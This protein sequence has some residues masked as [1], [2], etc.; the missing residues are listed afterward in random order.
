MNL[1]EL[2]NK[3]GEYLTYDHQ[4]TVTIIDVNSGLLYSIDTV[5]LQYDEDST[6]DSTVFISI[7]EI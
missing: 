6:P 4:A 3:L 1:Q 2:Y 7:E 5:N